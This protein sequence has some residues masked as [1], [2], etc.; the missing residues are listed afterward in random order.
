MDV[1]LIDFREPEE[2]QIYL[3]RIKWQ[4][5]KWTLLQ[6]LHDKFS[7]YGLIHCIMKIQI[8]YKMKYDLRGH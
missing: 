3:T 5:D 2:A 6:F 7:G 8:F 4:Q 1:E